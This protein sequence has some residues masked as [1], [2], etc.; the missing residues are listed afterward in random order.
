LGKALAAQL[1]WRFVDLDREIER[2]C[3]DTVSELF[4]HG[5]EAGFRKE[6]QKVLFSTVHRMKS[7]C[8]NGIIACGGGAPCFEHNLMFM[9]ANGF[10]VY[11]EVTPEI[12]CERL[13]RSSVKRRPLLLMQESIPLLQHIRTLLDRRKPFYE[14]AHWKC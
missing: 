10:V 9:K 8:P 13:Q 1:G 5:G 12:L 6:E 11:L 7:E 14:A 3:G 2:H 4:A